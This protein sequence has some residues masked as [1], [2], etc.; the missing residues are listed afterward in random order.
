[1]VSPA[2]GVTML[3]LMHFLRANSAQHGGF[4]SGGGLICAS[5]RSCR[6]LHHLTFP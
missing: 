4:A 1:M 5:L 2:K 6:A 3:G